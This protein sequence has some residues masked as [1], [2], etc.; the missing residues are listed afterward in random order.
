MKFSIRDLFLVT[1]IV[2]LSVGWGVDRWRLLV[3]ERE[4]NQ[5]TEDADWLATEWNG[6]F[7]KSEIAIRTQEILD[8][9]GYLPE[10]SA[11]APIPPKP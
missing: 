8:R 10:S 2:A 9:H 3:L 11:S 6:R 7:I 5:A 4:R 1:V